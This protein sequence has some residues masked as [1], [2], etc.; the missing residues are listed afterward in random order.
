MVQNSDNHKGHLDNILNALF[1][2]GYAKEEGVPLALKLIKILLNEEDLKELVAIVKYV[3]L[4]NLPDEE[5]VLESYFSKMKMQEVRQYEHFRK[6][7]ELL[8]LVDYFK[9][10]YPAKDFHEKIQQLLSKEI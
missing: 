1:K 10:K 9:R 3:P 6:R 8:L 4:L 5:Q 2:V 7:H